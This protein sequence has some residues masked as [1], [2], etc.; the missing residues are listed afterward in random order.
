LHCRKDSL[1]FLAEESL[2]SFQQTSSS[3][4]TTRENLL[5]YYLKLTNSQRKECF[6][7][8]CDAAAQYGVAQRTVQDWVNN[9]LIDAVLIGKRYK[10]Y[11]PLV[12]QHIR[13]CDQRREPI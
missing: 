12:E 11:R 1:V 5:D 10:V 13:Q 6:V 7:S 4:D 8:T 3:T 2:M 9:G